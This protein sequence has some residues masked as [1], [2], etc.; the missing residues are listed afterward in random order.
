MQTFFQIVRDRWLSSFFPFDVFNLKIA[1]PGSIGRK[2][3]VRAFEDISN[4]APVFIYT[5]VPVEALNCIHG[6]EDVGF[7]I[8]D[9]SIVLRKRINKNKP[10]G[11]ITGVRF[12]RMEDK[13]NVG[14]IALNNFKYSRF[15][16]DPAIEDRISNTIKAQWA[17]NYFEGKRGDE[18]IVSE[19]DGLI[20][21]FLQLLHSGDDLLID[22]IAVSKE[23]RNKNVA[24][25]MIDFAEKNLDG[26]R[27]IRVGT[28]AANIPSIG[29]YEKL[30]F[31]IVD[32]KQVLH[33]HR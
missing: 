4:R 22:L 33:Y 14:E 17:T 16:L 9:T 13:N 18:M 30:G 11:N 26:F 29:L 15:H 20:C 19:R 25:D 6:L 12:A 1:N 8:I 32:V 23:Y 3:C 27:H 10:L 28:Q 7:R 5:R 24:S 2:E 31:S 21:G